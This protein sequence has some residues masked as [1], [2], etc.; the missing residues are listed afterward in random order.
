M[1]S[2][3]PQL[4]QPLRTQCT[5]NPPKKINL[6]S[7]TLI[8]GPFGKVSGTVLPLAHQR[9]NIRWSADCYHLTAKPSRVQDM[10]RR[11]FLSFLRFSVKNELNSVIFLY[12]SCEIY[13]FQMGPKMVIV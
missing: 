2:T 10:E 6:H 7:D 3:L 8:V 1:Y 13:A 9:T 12:N 4:L 5:Q 11:I